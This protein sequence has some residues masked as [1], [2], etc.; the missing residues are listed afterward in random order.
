VPLHKVLCEFGGVIRWLNHDAG[1][2]VLSNFDIDLQQVIIIDFVVV[3][4]SLLERGFSWDKIVFH[5]RNYYLIV[6]LKELPG[7]FSASCFF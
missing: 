5:F 7:L 2:S 4:F 1:L 6:N 3:L